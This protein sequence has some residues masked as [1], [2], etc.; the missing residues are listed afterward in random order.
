MSK[1][2]EGRPVEDDPLARQSSVRLTPSAR[3]QQERSG[4]SSSVNVTE[5]MATVRDEGQGRRL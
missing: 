1:A 3:S 5:T 2:A 4:V